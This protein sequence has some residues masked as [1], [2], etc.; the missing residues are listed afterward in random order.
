MDNHWILKQHSGDP[1]Y[2]R[3]GFPFP[4]YPCDRCA[5]GDEIESEAFGQYG[6]VLGV[7]R[8]RYGEPMCYK[9]WYQ[10]EDKPDGG[11]FDYIQDA[12]V[13]CV[14]RCAD[15][16]WSLGRCGYRYVEGKDGVCGYYLNKKTGDVIVW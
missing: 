13:T 1:P 14:E 9:V 8:N 4:V 16:D 5:V 2:S 7:I 15:R 10:P 3:G 6:V 11:C 12:L